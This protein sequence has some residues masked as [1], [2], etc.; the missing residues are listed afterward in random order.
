MTFLAV[1]LVLLT[2]AGQTASS[3]NRAQ[4]ENA[5]TASPLSANLPGEVIRRGDPAYDSARAVFNGMI[6]RY[7]LVIVRCR[8]PGEVVRGVEFARERALPLAVRGGGHNVAGNAVCDDG[9]VLDLSPMKNLRIDQRSLTAVA[10]PGLT[11]GEFDRGSQA[12][13]L[14]TP[15]GIVSMTGIAGL[16]LG[17]GLGWLNGKYGLSCDNLLGAELVTANGRIVRAGPQDDE[18]LLWGLRGGGGNFGIVTSF[19]YRVHPVTT[20][21]AGGMSYPWSRLR[22]VLKGY[23]EL[24]HGAPDELATAV[25]VGLDPTRNPV[26]NIALCWCGPPDEGERVI[27]PLRSLGPPLAVSIESMPYVDWQST[28]DP[29]F[30]LGQQH[31]WKAGWLRHITEDVIDVL[32]DFIPRMPSVASG[33]GLQR[34]RGVAARV[35]PSAT[36]FANRVE[37]DDLLILSQWEDPS[38]S[39]R[40]ITWTRELFAGLSPHLDK[41]AYVNNLGNEG[42]QRVRAAYGPNYERLLALKRVYDPDNLFRLNQNIAPS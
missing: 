9:V 16:T 42:P 41:A 30:P 31:Y 7:P 21:L 10:G 4:E 8:E 36:A 13:G 14:A 23:A 12:H 38:D 19:R 33:V 17:G 29:G 22:D 26:L 11:L 5:M 1:V 35:E 32:E 20:V 18:D 39:D 15:L 40:N 27:R 34:M 24:M 2:Q 3:S 37:Q 25:S 28:P 6:D